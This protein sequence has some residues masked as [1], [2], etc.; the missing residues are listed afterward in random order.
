M[1]V[2]SASSHATS[3]RA[4][5]SART[6]ISRR[7]SLRLVI[8]SITTSSLSNDCPP[9]YGWKREIE[10]PSANIIVR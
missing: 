2:G 5:A 10:G 4:D 9:E 6:E 1:G 7:G 8:G 3:A